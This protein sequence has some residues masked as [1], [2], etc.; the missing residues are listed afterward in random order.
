MKKR[1]FW[2]CFFWTHYPQFLDTFDYYFKLP[3]VVTLGKWASKWLVTTT[4]RPSSSLSRKS[5]TS[6][7]STKM[8][9]IVTVT[10]CPDKCPPTFSSVFLMVNQSRK[11]AGQDCWPPQP[12]V[13][14]TYHINS[15]YRKANRSLALLRKARP[16]LSDAALASIVVPH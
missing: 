2:L 4:R 7:G 10:F 3:S 12:L 16:V 13:G 15:I 6:L 8:V 11:A 1:K 5:M 14:K 9:C